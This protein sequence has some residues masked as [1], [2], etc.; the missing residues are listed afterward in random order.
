[1]DL[2]ISQAADA[3]AGFWFG[4][5]ALAV[6]VGGFIINA[7]RSRVDVRKGNAE[8]ATLELDLLQDLRGEMSR[9]RERVLMAEAD[10]AAAQAELAQELARA[11][12]DRHDLKDEIYQRDGKIAR[13]Q[14][15]ISDL[16]ALVETLRA[17][18]GVIERRSDMQDARHDKQDQRGDR[19]DRRET[20]Q[21]DRQ[22][23]QDA[24]AEPPADQQP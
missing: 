21:D 13:L 9:L 16:E 11:S 2:L 6:T 24:R 18:T 22:A 5:V 4:L 3:G 8:S 12:K 15:R 7:Q 23:R 19:Q 17:Q 1:M 10:R 14:Q 20:R